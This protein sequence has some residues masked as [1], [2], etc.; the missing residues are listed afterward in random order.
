MRKVARD[1]SYI[2]KPLLIDSH[3]RLYTLV[4]DGIEIASVTPEG[5]LDVKT[6]SS[7]KCFAADYGT[8]QTA[9]V[10][11]TPPSGKRIKVIQ[12]YASTESITADIALAFGAV[13][14]QFFK[15]YTAKTQ[16][17]TGPVV[18]SIGGVDAKVYLTCG[19][20]TFIAIAYDEV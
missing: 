6:H 7:D 18:C 20:K 15:L 17:H 12:V 11:I 14:P 3:G 1:S 19:A 10:I 16:T 8:A 13:A 2:W 9:V 5:Y 4:T